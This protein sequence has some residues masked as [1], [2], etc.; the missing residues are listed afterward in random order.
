[1]GKKSRIAADERKSRATVAGFR[2]RDDIGFPM[3]RPRERSS[4]GR[5]G[6]STVS[7]FDSLF[8]RCERPIVP[9]V[10]LVSSLALPLF[11]QRPVATRG[12]AKS[13]FEALGSKCRP[14]GTGVATSENPDRPVASWVRIGAPKPAGPIVRAFRPL[15]KLGDRSQS[16]REE[17][18]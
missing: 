3:H 2:F 13:V 9:F 17:E 1:M 8:D 14:S 10:V 11:R 6:I 4:C 15:L 16:F 18:K 12:H 5:H 7:R